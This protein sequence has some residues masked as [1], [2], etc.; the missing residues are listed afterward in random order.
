[1]SASGGDESWKYLMLPLKAQ[2]RN[3]MKSF[4]SGLPTDPWRGCIYWSLADLNPY[5]QVVGLFPFLGARA[6]PLSLVVTGSSG[7]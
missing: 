5:S 4:L 2:I 7:K 1:M 3:A 6:L